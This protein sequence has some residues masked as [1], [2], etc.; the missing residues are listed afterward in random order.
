MKTLNLPESENKPDL[1]QIEQRSLRNLS[2]LIRWRRCIL[3]SE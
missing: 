1:Q 3:N 2:M